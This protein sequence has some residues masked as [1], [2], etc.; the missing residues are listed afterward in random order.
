MELSVLKLLSKNE[1]PLLKSFGIR[2]KIQY[3]LLK[4]REKVNFTCNEMDRH[5]I[6]FTIT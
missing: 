5:I 1:D 4:A 3:K 6:V 2:L